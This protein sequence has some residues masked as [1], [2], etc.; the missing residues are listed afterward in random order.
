MKQV[1]TR[2]PFY[3]QSA[4]GTESTLGIKIW[5]G[6]STSIP[7]TL[8]YELSKSH[9]EQGKAT[10]EISELINDYIVQNFANTDATYVPNF[11]YFTLT[12]T[13]SGTGAVYTGGTES[14]V[15]MALEGYID[16]DFVQKYINDAD[17]NLKTNLIFNEPMEYFI[18]TGQSLKL[19]SNNDNFAIISS[20]SGFSTSETPCSKFDAKKLTFVNKYGGKSDIW[21][22]AKSVQSNRFKSETYTSSNFDYDS[23]SNNFS[24][25][26]NNNIHTNGKSSVKLNTDYV[27][28][29]YNELMTQ[30]KMS[31]YVWLTEGSDVQ[32]VSVKGTS[33]TNLTH[34]NDG[35][36]QFSVDIE[37]DHNIAKSIK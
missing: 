24:K 17:Y 4:N 10:Y 5:T 18:P 27:N 12:Q 14:F 25:H 6:S 9:N 2:S 16:G 33:H 3:F 36:I 7:A 26:T 11:V 28:E 19:A 34:V 15:M 1:M 21:F 22:T 31:D 23:L 29:D 35:L 37:L 13:E 8:T 32:P 30:L 20:A